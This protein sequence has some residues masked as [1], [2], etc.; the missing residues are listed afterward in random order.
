MKLIRSEFVQDYSTY[1]FGYTLYAILET[2]DKLG[3]IYAQGFLP[4]TGD[5]SLAECHF[6]MARSLRVN[7][8]EFSYISENRRLMRKAES[9]DIQMV[10]HRKEDIL[11]DEIR[12]FCLKFGQERFKGGLEQS[13]LNYIFDQ[14]CGTHIYSFEIDGNHVAYILAGED[15][16]AIQYWFCF[17]DTAYRADFPLG[18]YLMTFMNQYAQDQGKQ[19]MYLG[20]C[21]GTSASYKFKDFKGIEFWDGCQW[22]ND[23][24]DLKNRIKTDHLVKTV[25]LYKK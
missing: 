15:D 18:K 7:L 13:R 9:Y 22:N 6:Y 21:Y 25:D 5:T 1:T 12:S 8:S 14:P 16:Q 24:S 10:R 4:Y 20:T 17:Y 19:Y 3:D 11:D 23:V 2:S